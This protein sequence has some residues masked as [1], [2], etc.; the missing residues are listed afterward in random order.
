VTPR[1]SVAL[2][3][4]NEEKLIARSLQSLRGHVDE[5][6]CVDTGST[7]RTAAIAAENGAIVHHWPWRDD[8]AA[9]RNHASSLCTGDWIMTWDADYVIATPQKTFRS[10]RAVMHEPRVAAASV[11]LHN[12]ASIKNHSEKVARGHGRDGKPFTLALLFRNMEPERL[13]DGIIHETP[14]NWILRRK[15]EGYESVNLAE[16][17]IVHYGYDPKHFTAADKGARNM[18]LLLRAAEQQPDNPIPLTYLALIYAEHQSGC[19]IGSTEDEEYRKHLA[20]TSEESLKAAADMVNRVWSI[21]SKLEG[22][23]LLRLC[24]ARCKVGFRME[25]MGA[26]LADGQHGAEVMWDATRTWDREGPMEH[27]DMLLFKGLS[28]EMLAAREDA[29]G[30]VADAAAHKAA[31]KV[32]YARSLEVP[33]GAMRFVTSA[34]AEERLKVLSV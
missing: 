23:H 28:C 1:L 21:R 26:E 6:I 31:A 9:A 3:A 7:D 19:D 22:V 4:K 15:A 12:A 5:I 14:G 25:S 2:I 16:T 34:T 29:A 10:V 17:N 18:R 11:W 8:F 33:Y 20:M 13:Y 30:Y 32:F 24:V 27:P